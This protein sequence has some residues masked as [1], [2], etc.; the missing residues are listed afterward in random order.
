MLRD[1]SGSEGIDHWSVGVL[2]WELLLGS[3]PFYAEG[4]DLMLH[5]IETTPLVFDDS[6]A[7]EHRPPAA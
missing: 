7:A 3:P 6:S 4:P 5:A 1:G 2:L